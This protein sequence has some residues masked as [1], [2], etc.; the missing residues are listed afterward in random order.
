ML[1]E[2]NAQY[3]KMVQPWH[4]VA[5]CTRQIISSDLNPFANTPFYR[6]ASASLELFERL[7]TSYEEPE[8]GLDSTTIDNQT[9][10]FTKNL[11]ASYCILDA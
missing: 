6:T 8:W 1:Y 4:H 11:F 10:W 5:N 3:M 7:T 9:K 2:L